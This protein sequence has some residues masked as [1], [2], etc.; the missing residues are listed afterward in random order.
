MLAR[1]VD[2]A[3]ERLLDYAALL[4]N[5]EREHI[6]QARARRALSCDALARVS[7]QTTSTDTMAILRRHSPVLDREGEW[8]PLVAHEYGLCIHA[9]QEHQVAQ[10]TGSLVS[11]VGQNGA[12]HWVTATAAPCTSLFKPVFLDGALPSIGSPVGR[13]DQESLW[14]RHE[15]LHRC[16]LK[17]SLPHFVAAIRDER[18]RLEAQFVERVENCIGADREARQRTMQICWAEAE[19]AETRWLRLVAQELD[20]K[21]APDDAYQDIWTQFNARAGFSL[22]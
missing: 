14:W 19:A 16:A 1:N 22:R 20:G 15:R 17:R 6:G 2:E 11:D 4:G 8:T 3:A 21:A 7:G 18:D 9:G 12:V 13:A 10:T 5:S